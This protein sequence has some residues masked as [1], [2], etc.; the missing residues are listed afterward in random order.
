MLW[1][2]PFDKKATHVQNDAPYGLRTSI[3]EVAT[4]LLLFKID[5]FSPF[6]KT[7]CALNSCSP[8]VTYGVATPCSLGAFGQ[9]PACLGRSA[10]AHLWCGRS[11]RR[12][13]CEPFSL[14]CAQIEAHGRRLTRS[15]WVKTAPINTCMCMCAC[16]YVRTSVRTYVCT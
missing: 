16:T 15:S 8:G 11:G 6:P 13:I 14:V 1:P 2:R 12:F 5:P 9:L 4:E 10:R 3:L 7:N